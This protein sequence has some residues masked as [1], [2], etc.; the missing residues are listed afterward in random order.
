[1]VLLVLRNRLIGILFSGALL[2]QPIATLHRMG[3]DAVRQELGGKF[4]FS[5]FFLFFFSQLHG[6]L[7]CTASFLGCIVVG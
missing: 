6:G 4:F 5:F 7:R 3:N 1:M 2:L